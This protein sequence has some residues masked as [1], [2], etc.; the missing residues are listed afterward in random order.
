[1]A[2]SSVGR[3]LT[4]RAEA[5]PVVRRS[6]GIVGV[7]LVVLVWWLLTL[8]DSPETRVVS[9]VLLPSPGEV[10][11]GIPALFTERALVA[12]IAA[13]LKRVFGGFALAILIGVPLGIVAGSYRLFDAF[14]RP[15]SVFARNVPVAVLI[16]LTI[17][18]F[19]I[20]E[21]QKMMFIFISTVPFVFFDAARAIAAVHDRY[22]ETAQTLGASPAQVVSKVLIALAMP[23]IFGSLRSLFG[24]AFGYI[25]L[26]ELV[27]AEHGLGYLLMTSQRRG[28]TEHIFAILILIGLLAYGIDRLLFWFQRGLFP[29]RVEND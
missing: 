17:L 18:W 20:D 14:T 9:P 7:G 10:V 22:V 26:A 19:G 1:V 6:A 2:Q 11:K 5:P 8:G 29:Y 15:M 16:P 4:L 23:D 25:M 21:T 12:S 24:L 13:T 28:L 27:N 3:L